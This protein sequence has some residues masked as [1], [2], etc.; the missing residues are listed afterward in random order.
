MGGNIAGI[1]GAQIFRQDDR[2]LYQRGFAVNISILVAGLLLAVVRFVDDMLRRRKAAR[3]QVLAADGDN[4]PSD[5]KVDSSDRGV[6][7]QSAPV[8]T[9][10]GILPVGV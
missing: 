1:Y 4:N 5:E 2:P 9:K 7:I 3:I 10:G 6:D 8:S